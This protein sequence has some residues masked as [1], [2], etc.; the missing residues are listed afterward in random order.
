MFRVAREDEVVFCLREIRLSSGVG[1]S[2]GKGIVGGASGIVARGNFARF[3]RASFRRL[4]EG[5]RDRRH[6]LQSETTHAGL[7]VTLHGG[8]RSSITRSLCETVTL[9]V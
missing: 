5:C 6:R 8:A 7:G 4:R 3:P 1:T 2:S 9:S